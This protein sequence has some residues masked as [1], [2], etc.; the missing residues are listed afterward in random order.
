MRLSLVAAAVTFFSIS[1]TAHADLTGDTL[2][3]KYLFPNQQTVFNDLGN[4]TVP[5]NGEVPGNSGHYTLSANQITLTSDIEQ[6][7]NS[8]DFNGFLFT[9]ISKDPMITGAT[10]DGSSTLFDAVV[11]F[12]SDSVAINL[13]SLGLVSAGDF[14]TVDLSFAPPSS[15]TPEPSS[16]AL[17]GTG[18]LGLAGVA[19]RRFTA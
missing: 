5:G 12:T 16:I 6:T 2:N 14:V 7:F 11:T 19:R 3:V 4:T 10:L 1:L 17:L 13:Q 9:D 18:M 8:A 15:V